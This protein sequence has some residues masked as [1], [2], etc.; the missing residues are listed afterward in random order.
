MIRL[1]G[2]VLLFAHDTET[3]VAR[4]AALAGLQRRGARVAVPIGPLG[5]TPGQNPSRR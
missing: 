2:S 4:H 5:H 3:V 1:V